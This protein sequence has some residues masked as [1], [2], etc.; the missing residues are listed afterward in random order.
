MR[1]LRYC[2]RPD[3]SSQYL[4][5]LPDGRVRYQLRRHAGPGS[6]EVIT[7]E[8]TDLLR[9]LAAT[10]PRPYQHRTVYHGIFASAASRRLEISPAASRARCER[11]RC[12]AGSRPSHPD[13]LPPPKGPATAAA[14]RGVPVRVDVLAMMQA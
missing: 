1:T 12:H 2:A 11:P 7:L 6:A 10:L 9:R 3:F 4:S 5:R 13:A 8:P 14:L